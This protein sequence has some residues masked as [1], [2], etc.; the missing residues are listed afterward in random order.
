MNKRKTKRFVD[1]IDAYAESVNKRKIDHS[2]MSVIINNNYVED[3]L[4]DANFVGN[5]HPNQGHVYYYPDNYYSYFSNSAWKITDT[6]YDQWQTQHEVNVSAPPPEP[7]QIPPKRFL[8]LDVSMQSL[9]DM[10]NILNTHEYEADTEYNID[11]RSLHNIKSELVELNAMVGLRALKQSILE[12]LIYFMQGLHLGV[13]SSEFKHIV[14]YGS[15]GTGK[16][17]IAKIVGRMYSKLGVLKKNVFKKVT[18]HDMIAGYLGQTAIKTRKIVDDCLGGVLF[19]DE[20]YSLGS[21]DSFSKECL[22]TLCD[23]LSEHKDELMV[24]IAGYEDELNDTFFKVNAG[25]KSR[26]IWKFNMGEYTPNELMQIFQKK[27]AEQNWCFYKESEITERWF[28]DKKTNFKNYGRD[29]EMLLLYTKIAHG[30]R[31]Y[32]KSAD[33]RKKITLED[34][35]SGYD[36]FTKN[37][38][39]KGV[40]EYL[41]SIYM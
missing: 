34:L 20:A 31:I 10:I 39:E 15:P 35:N 32:G 28:S 24:I 37:K 27:V 30:K 17:E 21:D 22:D 7:T 13:N 11:L 25:L 18:R 16:T 4:Y 12:Q 40:P 38:K 36:V 1:F 41:S 9:D 5:T 23:A 29:M 2:L 6:T 33:I 8:H 14:I 3:Q 26:F 19:I